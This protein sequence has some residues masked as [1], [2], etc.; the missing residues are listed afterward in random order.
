M[1][2]YEKMQNIKISVRAKYCPGRM[3]ESVD[4]LLKFPGDKEQDSA[5]DNTCR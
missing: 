3:G 2:D 4:L 5:K 1:K